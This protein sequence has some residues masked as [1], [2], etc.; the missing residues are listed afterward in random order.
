MPATSTPILHLY[1]HQPAALFKARVNMASITYPVTALV[2]DTVT[3]GAFGDIQ[4][5]M[6]LTL[7]SA[8]GLDDL[9]RVRV[10]NVATSTTIPIGRISQGL[11]DGTLSVADNMYITVWDDYRVWAKLP[12]YNV[13]TGIDYKD[14]DVPVGTYNTQIPPVANCGPGTAAYTSAGIITV[15]FPAGGSN[16]SFAMADSATISTYAW[17]VKD[18]TI[19]VGTAA[20]AVITAIFPAGFRWVALTVTDSNGKPH[21]ARC[22]VLAVN[23][24][25]DVTVENF[26]VE[27]HR[28]TQN[29]QTLGFRVLEDVP[30]TTYPDGCL[31]MFWWDAPASATDRSHMKFIGW[32]QNDS[33]SIRAQRTGLLRDTVLN[34]VDIAGRLADL[35]GFPQVV[36]RD[37]QESP[38]A[39]IPTLDINKCLHY[40]IFWHSTALSLADFFLPVVGSSYP[41]MHL[42][43]T[44]SSLYDQINGMAQKI[45]P[46][47][48][49]VCNTVGQ[50]SVLPDWMLKDVGDRPTTAPILTEEYWS[51]LRFE[52]TRPPR[53]HVLRGGAVVVSTA[54]L[55]IGGIDS[56]PLAFSIAPGDAFGQGVNEVVRGEGL[57]ISQA[58]L[59][60][61]TGH[62]YARLN[63][64]YGPFSIVEPSGDIWDYEPA[65]MNRVQ[66]NVSATTAAQRG[67]DFTTAAG[68]VKAIDLRYTHTKGGVWVSPTLTWERETSG[69]A[70]QTVTPAIP[71]TPDY[72]TPAPWVPPVDGDTRY[73][74]GSMKGYILWD[75]AH[76]MRT[77]DIQASSP[78]WALVDTGITGTIYDGQYVHVNATTVGMWLLT[79]DAVWWCADI[80]ATTPSWTAKL[81]IATVIAA[82]VPPATGTVEFACM[83]NYASEPG[84]LIV[85][86]APINTDTLY[87]HAYFWHTH[88]YGATWTQVDMSDFTFIS[89]GDERCY[90]KAGRFA[91][92]IFRSSPGTIWC[93]RQTDRTGASGGSCAVFRSED[94]GHTWSKHLI[95]DV[96]T[97]SAVAASLLNPFPAIGDPSY[98]MRSSGTANEP[99]L[100]RS[101]N[102]WTTPTILTLP[103][104]YNYVRTI[105]RPNKRTF[106]NTHVMAWHHLTAGGATATHLLESFDQGVNWSVLHQDNGNHNTPNGWPSDVLQW[107]VVGSNEGGTVNAKTI[108]LTL[109]NFSTLLDKQGNLTTILSNTWVNGL[110]SGFSLP[111]LG[112]NL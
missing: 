103:T 96:Y 86:T 37:A 64:R 66:L 85:A 25:A 36:G 28:L 55:V 47:H 109:N 95:E 59:N 91:M 40:L 104:G 8:E 31:V 84:Y 32:H 12:Y 43:T 58:T 38:W 70:A 73:Y 102:S 30:R 17:D 48:L 87:L 79:S 68:M 65:L 82:D 69:F 33:V 112:P 97:N 60:A 63:A 23:A 77:W 74:Y 7:G 50:L 45:V 81:P 22:P 42:T 76:V 44:G 16:L 83:Y 4:A 101:T 13:D 10:Q 41:T 46:D 75:G 24:D 27:S 15:Q 26:Q 105:F 19:T 106:D 71:A 49:V 6:T 80:M 99:R 3:L 90:S 62:R 110:G 111:R 35:P 9:G 52:Y 100:Y 5:D 53:V 67:M 89:S 18:G 29:G 51:E 93:V 21:T 108:R 20:S 92:N 107:V 54:W 94:L 56:L 98:V 39:E 1:L 78:T 14:G 72:E 88:N 61:C 2:F 57:T 34:C 11:E